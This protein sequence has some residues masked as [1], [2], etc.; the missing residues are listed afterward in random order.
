MKDHKTSLDKFKKV[1][2]IPRLFSNHNCLKL[3]ISNRNKTGKFTNMQKFKNTLV[4]NQPMDQR[5]NK[6]KS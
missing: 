6:K 4:N 1:E 2:I 5:R 3:K